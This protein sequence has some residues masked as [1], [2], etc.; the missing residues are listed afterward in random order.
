MGGYPQLLEKKATPQKVNDHTKTQQILKSLISKALNTW[1][2][3][4]P[5]NTAT[6]TATLG[7]NTQFPVTFGTRSCQRHKAQT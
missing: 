3:I 2:S 6:K 4:L 5:L 1:P 7:V